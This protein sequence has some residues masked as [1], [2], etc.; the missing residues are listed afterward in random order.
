MQNHQFFEH[1]TKWFWFWNRFQKHRRTVLFFWFWNHQRADTLFVKCES[2][3]GLE[4]SVGGPLW[5][6]T[7]E[8]S[9]PYTLSFY[10]EGSA[11]CWFQKSKKEPFVCVFG[12]GSKI[13]PTW[14]HCSKICVLQIST[15][16]RF[17]L[18]NWNQNVKRGCKNVAFEFW[19]EKQILGL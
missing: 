19:P 2:L 18:W 8:F 15:F 11:R 16:Y 10:K 6:E 7:T 3:Y 17:L 4:T 1:G 12:I 5:G 9:K 13:G 14:Y